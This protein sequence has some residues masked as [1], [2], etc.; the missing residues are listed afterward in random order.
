MGPTLVTGSGFSDINFLHDAKN[1]SR[2]TLFFAY[3]GNFSLRMRSLDRISTFCLKSN[4]I[5]E[6]GTPVFL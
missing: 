6:F 3:F 4:V 5:F 1:F 2:P